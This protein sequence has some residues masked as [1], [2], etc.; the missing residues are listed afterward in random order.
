VPLVKD[1]QQDAFP[2]ADL[3]VKDAAAGIG[4]AGAAAPLIAEAFGLG[5]LQRCELPGEVM[6]LAPGEL[7]QRR[8]GQPVDDRGPCGAQIT[9]CEGEQ[10]IVGGEPD[11]GHSRVMTVIFED[12]AGLL[13]QA[14]DAGGGDF[15]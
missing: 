5:G 7:G 14:A 2:V 11:R 3:L 4:L 15:Q 9:V 6:Q 10:G 1:G 12:L 8:V 13:D